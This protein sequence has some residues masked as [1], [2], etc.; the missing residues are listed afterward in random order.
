MGNIE[1]IPDIPDQ[2]RR[3]AEIRADCYG[4]DEESSAFEVYL[5][6]AL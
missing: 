6:D 1:D 4:R 2:A 5:T 3:L